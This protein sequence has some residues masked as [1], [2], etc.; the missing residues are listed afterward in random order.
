VKKLKA[1]MTIPIGNLFK[2][3]SIFLIACYFSCQS[4]SFAMNRIEVKEDGLIGTFYYSESSQEQPP[5]LIFGGSSGGN[6]FDSYQNYPEDLVKSGY[7]VLSIAY[8]D[9]DGNSLLPDKLR[10]IPLEYF[11][12]AMDWLEKQPQTREGGIAVIG[13]SR[14]GEA[15]LLLATIYPEISTVIAIVPSAYIGGAH[16]QKRAITGGA[17]TLNGEE[18]PYVDYQKAVANYTPWWNIMYD[19]KEVQPY[20]I[21]VEEMSAA[22][23]LL[24]GTKDKVWPSTEM[25]ERIMKRLTSKNY[26]FPYEHISYE[27]G[28]NI[29]MTSWPDIRRFLATHFSP[30]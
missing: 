18:I 30:Q 14:G 23:L 10:H 24:S 28:H 15:A 12:K 5:I 17:W 6:F 2:T 4:Q 26:Q 3:S 20:A 11:K 7:A 9:Y 8:F 29:R 21:P 19:L 13:N 27:A 22:V 16:N 1:R 25:S